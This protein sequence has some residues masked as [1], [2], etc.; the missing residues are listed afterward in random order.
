MLAL[1]P[2]AYDF[3]VVD[4]GGAELAMAFSAN[5]PAS[6]RSLYQSLGWMKEETRLL[7]N[8]RADRPGRYRSFLGWLDDPGWREVLI[9]GDRPWRRPRRARFLRVGSRESL[10]ERLRSGG[11]VFGCGNMAGLPMTLVTHPEGS[12]A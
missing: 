8:H 11:R 5:D 7:F 4:C 9:I 3:R 6:T 1:E 12:L 2:D 10:E